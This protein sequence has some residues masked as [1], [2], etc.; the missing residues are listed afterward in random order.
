ML[1]MLMTFLFLTTLSFNAYGA[2]SS[3]Y[4]GEV[5]SPWLIVGPCQDLP[6]QESP[7][8]EKICLSEVK[9]KYKLWPQ[10]GE[11]VEYYSVYWKIDPTLYLRVITSYSIHYTKLYEWRGSRGS[12]LF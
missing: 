4:E 1:R 11:P 12:P 8:V 6:L 2:L 3:V 10:M 9:I 7:L 5:D